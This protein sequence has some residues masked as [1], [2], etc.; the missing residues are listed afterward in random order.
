MDSAVSAGK[1]VAKKVQ[2][3]AEDIYIG[4]EKGDYAP[5]IGRKGRVLKDDPSKYPD[6]TV[7][8][9]GW[10]GGEAGLQQW[11]EVWPVPR[12]W[13]EHLVP[14]ELCKDYPGT[15]AWMNVAS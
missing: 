11:V 12:A 6:R 14:R 15:C 4:F 3:A 8:T 1:Q 2:E 13:P 9:G 5:R 10:S 7:L